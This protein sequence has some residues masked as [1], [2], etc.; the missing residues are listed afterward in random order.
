MREKRYAFPS[1]LYRL[2]GVIGQDAT[3]VT[4][5]VALMTGP[6]SMLHNAYQQAVLFAIEEDT[7]HCLHI[8]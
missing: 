3:I 5:L 1:N 8:A 4:A 2:I 7:T 6:T